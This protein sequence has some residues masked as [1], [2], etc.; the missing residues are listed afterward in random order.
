MDTSSLEKIKRMIE[1]N[2]AA[3]VIS[4][5]TESL[6]S[7][8][9]KEQKVTAYLCIAIAKLSLQLTMMCIND[10][11]A[12]ISIEPTSFAYFIRG[13]A[14]LWDSDEDKAVESWKDGLKIGG[15][16]SLF[17]ILNSLISNYNIR[18]LVFTYKYKI[19][20]LLNFFKNFDNE[21][22]FD[23]SDTQSGF[24]ELRKNSL[25][26]AINQFNF[27]ISVNP[28]N[29]QALKGRG[30][31]ECMVGHWKKSIIDLT[32]VI[33]MGESVAEASKYRALAYAALGY[34]SAA[35]AD[36]TV[37]ITKKPNDFEAIL[38]RA[39]LHMIRNNYNLALADFHT[40]P[41]KFYD[42]KIYTALAECFYAIGDIPK[43]LDAILK[44]NSKTDHRTFYYRYLIRR[45]QG[46]FNEAAFQLMK[47]IELL[48]SFFLS[49]TAG[50]FM[51]ECGN[52]RNSILYYKNAILQKENDFDTLYLLSLALFQSGEELNG[53]QIL[54]SLVNEPQN[55][56]D[57]FDFCQNTYNEFNI[58]GDLKSFNKSLHGVS[59][60]NIAKETLKKLVNII[61]H[62]DTIIT[63]ILFE[64][65]NSSIPNDFHFMSSELTEI[66]QRMI[67][68][69]YR[70]GIKCFPFV[71]EIITNTRTI[72]CLG[73]C[74]LYLAKQI[75]S[76]FFHKKVSWRD[77]LISL[78]AIMS[79]SDLNLDIKWVFDGNDVYEE[80]A[81]IFYLQKGERRSPRFGIGIK[82]AI[83]CL[84]K[85]YDEIE[86]FVNSTT[87]SFQLTSFENIYSYFQHDFFYNGK[88]ITKS[89]ETL[90]TPTIHLHY[91]GSFGF[92][93]FVRPPLDKNELL[94]YFNILDEEWNLFYQN[95]SACDISVTLSQLILMLWVIQP[96][97]H[98]SN[99]FGHIIYHSFIL[100][101]KDLEVEKLPSVEGELFIKQ[102]IQPSLMSMRQIISNQIETKSTK[103]EVAAS[104]LNY[105]SAL[106]TIEQ[107]F[108]LLNYVERPS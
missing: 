57:Q 104:S 48:P 82:G 31:A 35:V 21:Y 105:W 97:S 2:Q 88:W 74:V 83:N 84:K 50:D 69:A 76:Q 45:D 94:K 68:D 34:Y 98:F 15:E 55:E 18:T 73:F 6:E 36:F 54:Q 24:M 101:I 67:S 41:V 4:Y 49:R 10:C 12:S 91:L 87:E 23:L 63:Q 8:C 5:Y 59:T 85:K 13:I 27:I 38:E 14:E 80:N 92:D 103:S 95:P 37:A 44:A 108:N 96:I 102:F 20:K 72:R 39:K 77:M 1:M 71:P 66:E 25:N 32:K 70:L 30:L 33:D 81:P 22:V 62:K 7:D 106:P 107:M 61:N 52:F 26:S 93:L 65:D 79:Y 19:V 40:V 9:T 46:H 90:L 64:N 42:S 99:E 3:D 43:A 58:Y 28:N 11:N 51:Y 89:N 47:A 16:I 78:Q 75:K 60:I 53:I 86:K 29:S 17:N 100:A 56:E